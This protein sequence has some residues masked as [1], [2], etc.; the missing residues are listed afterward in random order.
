MA[1]RHPDKVNTH[2]FRK[3]SRY[4]EKVNK[5]LKSSRHPDSH[6]KISA[7]IAGTTAVLF[8]H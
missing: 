6:R 1:I 7:S 4:P 5:F 2:T 3:L 8:Q